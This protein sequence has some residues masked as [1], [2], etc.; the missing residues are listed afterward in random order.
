MRRTPQALLLLVAAIVITAPQA[1]SKDAATPAAPAASPARAMGAGPVFALPGVPTWQAPPE[2]SVDMQMSS[3][4]N[5]VTMHRAIKGESF[6]TEMEA[7][8]HSMIMLERAEEPGM[9]YNIM[10][11]EK[12]AMKMNAAKMQERAE[13]MGKM[14]KEEAQPPAKEVVPQ[15][16]KLG[17]EKVNG[18]DAA[19]FKVTAE[20]HTALMWLDPANGAPL[21]MQSGEATIEWKNYKV[22]P[23]PAKLF[24][25]PKEY[26]LIDMDEQMKQMEK[27]G[28]GGMMRGAMGGGMPMG[29]GGPGGGGGML[30]GM[31]GRYGGQMGQGFGQQIGA[32]IGASF[33][34]P[35]GAMAG[36]YIGGR[37]GGWIGRRVATAVTPDVGPG[38]T[39]K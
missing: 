38:A 34:G 12:M 35:L 1:R 19:K 16:E 30:E 18:V 20:D 2:Y 26:Q 25:V 27:M 5:Q 33:G 17:S 23:Q 24:E 37:V 15:I 29:M 39:P 36:Q 22:G 11:A 4:E 13:K 7:E 14:P 10:P 32:G 28:G 9:T 8:G 3:G 6:R 31:A 21:K